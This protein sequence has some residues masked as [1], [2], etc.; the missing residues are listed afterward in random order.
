VIGGNQLEFGLSKKQI[1]MMNNIGMRRKKGKSI[2]S[3]KHVGK[4][5]GIGPLIKILS[6]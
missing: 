1:S 2:L 6:W 5:A 4:L 3:L